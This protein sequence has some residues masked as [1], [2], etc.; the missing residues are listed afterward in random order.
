MSP[1]PFK[2]YGVVPN[3]INE[4]TDNVLSMPILHLNAVV[5]ERPPT[6]QTKSCRICY[7]EET[8]EHKVMSPCL[9]TGS[10][11][12]MHESCLKE[13]VMVKFSDVQSAACELCKHT[14]NYETV[15]VSNLKALTCSKV[16]KRVIL[17]L[18][19]MVGLAVLALIV[20]SLV[21]FYQ[22]QADSASEKVQCIV[23]ISLCGIT[24]LLILIVSIITMKRLL[25][26]YSI[27]SWK[28]TPYV[29][30]STPTGRV[31]PN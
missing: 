19:M 27:L 4:T 13:W 30:S 28:I 24:G 26:G 7:E 18:L 14:F 1:N 21:D 6:P 3:D 25:F 20:L 23:F 5:T 29:P 15:L 8:E 12:Y 11:Q 31:G 22:N 17:T 10:V 9:C 2:T 16:S